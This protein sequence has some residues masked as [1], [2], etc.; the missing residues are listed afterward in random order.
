L[1]AKI[2]AFD[3]KTM[4]NLFSRGDT[5]AN[6]AVSEEGSVEI[7]KQLHSALAQHFDTPRREDDLKDVLSTRKSI[8]TRNSVSFKRC[9][10]SE[11]NAI[12][13]IVALRKRSAVMWVEEEI[14][15]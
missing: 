14:L 6:L 15:H 12:E 8:H 1:K 4:T 13:H 7:E 9:A 11:G 10:S 3:K 2:K 5:S